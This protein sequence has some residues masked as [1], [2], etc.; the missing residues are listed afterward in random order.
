LENCP[1][2]IRQTLFVVVL[3]DVRKIIRVWGFANRLKANAKSY[4]NSPDYFQHGPQVNFLQMGNIS[5]KKPSLG[6]TKKGQ[7]YSQ[8]FHEIRLQK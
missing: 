4:L 2:G 6:N 1:T 8:P 3:G 7:P 5:A